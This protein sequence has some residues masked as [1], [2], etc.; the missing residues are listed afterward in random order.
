MG[1]NLSYELGV[2]NVLE[3][4][5]LAQIPLIWQERN[6]GGYLLVFAGG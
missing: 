3:M 6:Q 4:L 5:N 2:T 1:F